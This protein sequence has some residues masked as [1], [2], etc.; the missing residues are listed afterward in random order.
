MTLNFGSRGGSIREDFSLELKGVNFNGVT[1]GRRALLSIL[2]SI[3]LALSMAVGL[4][5]CGGGPKGPKR[6][7]ISGAVTR[8][9][10]PMDE[11]NIM[12]TPTSQGMA[13]STEIKN[14]EY[15]FN[16]EDGPPEGKYKAV[17]IAYPK[18][19]PTFKG[20]KNEAPILPDDRFKKKMPAKGW[21]QEIEVKGGT[22][23]KQKIDISLDSK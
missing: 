20:K 4:P 21:T 14:G 19:D 10:F 22:E 7:A 13:V 11:G 8:E 2:L 12:L 18:Y 16:D 17:I 3:L 15:K 1:V 5:G 9:G 23:S 6:Y